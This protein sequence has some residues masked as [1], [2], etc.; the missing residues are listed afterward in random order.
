M[1][2]QFKT[3]KGALNYMARA[4]GMECMDTREG[5]M[6]A[7]NGASVDDLA[8]YIAITEAVWASDWYGFNTMARED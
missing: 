2:K 8:T 7:Q 3:V 4:W 1:S 5:F 6:M